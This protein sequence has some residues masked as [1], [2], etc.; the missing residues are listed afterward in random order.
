LLEATCN[1]AEEL[2]VG[3]FSHLRRLIQ[4]RQTAVLERE[5]YAAC[6]RHV[7]LG[8]RSALDAAEGLLLATIFSSF[9]WSLLILSFVHRR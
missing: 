7:S 2:Y 1:L 5:L 9:F 6:G 8:V 4:H 3:P